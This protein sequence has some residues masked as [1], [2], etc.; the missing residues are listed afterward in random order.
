MLF[1]KFCFYG[2]NYCNLL[3]ATGLLSLKGHANLTYLEGQISP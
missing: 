1:N 2:A 3:I